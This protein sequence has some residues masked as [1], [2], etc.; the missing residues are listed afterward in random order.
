MLLTKNIAQLHLLDS[1]SHPL[2]RFSQMEYEAAKILGSS[3]QNIDIFLDSLDNISEHG[4]KW[5]AKARGILCLSG[6]KEISDQVALHL[7]QH[8]G[9][10]I[11]NGIRELSDT[12]CDYL[13]QHE[14]LV[15]LTGLASLTDTPGHIKIARR[16]LECTCGPWPDDPS[17]PFASE[18]HLENL[19]RVEPKVA[20]ILSQHLGNLT[21]GVSQMSE[22]TA[23]SLSSHQGGQLDLPKLQHISESVAQWLSVHEGGLGLCGLRQLSEGAA[24]HL[25]KHRYS[26]F[27][28][29][30]ETI[31]KTSV[32]YLRKHPKL[33]VENMNVHIRK[34]LQKHSFLWDWFSDRF[35]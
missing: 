14:G 10:I 12:A 34:Q 2:N 21:L 25:S 6:L 15:D 20:S 16:I 19:S 23:R 31:S 13:S 29:G 9:E 5:I 22:E 28:S 4:A 18:L 32:R 1:R 26:L 33:Y 11:L 7:A 17:R 35:R 3:T 30:L 27:L 8:K 24:F